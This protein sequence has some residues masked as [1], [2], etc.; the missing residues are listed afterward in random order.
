M[1]MHRMVAHDRLAHQSRIV[2]RLGQMLLS[3]GASAFRVKHSMAKLARAVGIEQHHAQVTYTEIIATSYANGTFRTGLAEQRTMGV[4]ADRID[5]LNNYVA[6]IK[7]RSVLVED[8]DAALDEI[9]KVPALYDWF[10]N[11]AASGLACAAFAF[12]N[13][14]GWVE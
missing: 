2:L 3:C 6:S 10:P 5:R 4:N 9:E 7:G 8:V 12:L 14:G 1:T 13:G 11:A